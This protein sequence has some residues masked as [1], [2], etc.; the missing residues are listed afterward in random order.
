MLSPRGK[1]LLDGIAETEA[2]ENYHSSNGGSDSYY[3]YSATLNKKTTSQ[4]TIGGGTAMSRSSRSIRWE[5]TLNLRTYV[6]AC[7]SVFY[8]TAMGYWH[9]YNCC[10][11]YSVKAYVNT[12]TQPSLS[13]SRTIGARIHK[14]S[15]S[16]F[17]SSKDDSQS[18]GTENILPF[19]PTGSTES[20]T[21]AAS[22]SASASRLG[23]LRGVLSCA[24]Y[25][26]DVLD[27][28]GNNPDDFF[29]SEAIDMSKEGLAWLDTSGLMWKAAAKDAAQRNVSVQ[30]YVEDIK[31]HIRRFAVSDKVYDRK[32]L[33]K[34][35]D[36]AFS[37]PGQFSL[38]LGGKSVG[39]SLVL[40]YLQK[41]YNNEGQVDVNNVKRLVLYVDARGSPGDLKTCLA[42]A[43]TSL[44]LQQKTGKLDQTDWYVNIVSGGV[45][46]VMLLIGG[47]T[48]SPF[49]DKATGDSIGAVV[50]RI[51]SLLL[52][53]DL[54]RATASIL[55]D[56]A[57]YA[58]T[59]DAFP[60]LVIDEA[61]VVMGNALNDTST[62]NVLIN[63][64][65]RT[66]DMKTMTVI[67]ASSEHAYPYRLE[68]EGLNLG[69]VGM[70][71]FAGEIPPRDMWN[72]LVNATY[73]QGPN[74]GKP[75]VDK[76][77]VGMGPELAELCLA[78]YGGHFLQVQ[79][80]MNALEL[81]KNRFEASAGLPDLT[82]NIVEC[83]RTHKETR[84]LLKEMAEYGFAP[85]TTSK[86]AAVELIVK[87][88]VGGVV[89]RKST[90]IGIA[91]TRWKAQQSV[92]LVPSSESVRLS[93]AM[94][95]LAEPVA[96]PTTGLG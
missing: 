46:G 47:I 68:R 44:P 36:D 76:P 8:V 6:F 32:R 57:K 75:V 38:L 26:P 72:L 41:R 17:T 42:N 43:Y 94:T 91:S 58:A 62:K 86:D 67:L 1:T 2:V 74:I 73:D 65:K 25:T 69:D 82:D 55:D 34:A 39:K 92:A 79:N 3:W 53:K 51:G 20:D 14:N 28:T 87:L 81:L 77:L 48:A 31:I 56:F 93:I 37:E 95:L 90:V 19:S 52:D 15:C 27:G 10:S 70:R 5:L 49:V 80:A 89:S 64:V 45:D 29:Y 63:L 16:L 54:E 35:L 9:C 78:A 60:V 12:K 33:L 21:N 24:D 71:I 7:L 22:A 50:K 11:A 4:T 84:P 96:E 85:I 83:L 59:H 61:N 23:L 13:C 30:E 66:K 18:E 40:R 88:N